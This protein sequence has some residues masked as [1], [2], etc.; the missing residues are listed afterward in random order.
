[1]AQAISCSKSIHDHRRHSPQANPGSDTSSHHHA[2]QSCGDPH[3][4]H[5]T[6]QWCQSRSGHGECTVKWPGC[7]G[8]SWEIL[9]G[10]VVESL[11]AELTKAQAVLPPVNV[12]IS[13]CK[14]FIE[15]SERR[16]VW[17]EAETVIEKEALSEGR[18]RLARMEEDQRSWRKSAI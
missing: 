12:Q 18:A 10:V 14:E 6:P 7:T 15:R 2:V 17:L 13:K 4:A 9:G 16:L 1:M 11:Q 5:S 8:S 3:Q